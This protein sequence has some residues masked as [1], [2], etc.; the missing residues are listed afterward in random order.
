MQMLEERDSAPL[1]AG[2][3]SEAVLLMRKARRAS[4]FLKA[5][6]HENRL[7]LLCLLAE[8]ERSVSELEAILNLRQ[9]T[10]SQQL[11]RLRLDGLVNARREGKA[12]HYSLANDDVR[13]MIGV[14]H[15]LF[16]A[17]TLC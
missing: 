8:K 5:L 16:C 17:D 3:E 9:P 12:I 15:R 10:I 7:L 13:A 11:A 14:L 1:P 2:T 6:S 4:E